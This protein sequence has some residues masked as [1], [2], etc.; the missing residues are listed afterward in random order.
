MAVGDARRAVGEAAHCKI[1]ILI[2]A[3]F[4]EAALGEFTGD[5]SVDTIADQVGL[6]WSITWCSTPPMYTNVWYFEKS[7]LGSKLMFILPR[8][9]GTRA[10]ATKER[11]APERAKKNE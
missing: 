7:S 1:G 5:G 11:P 10:A 4:L 9:S 3:D 8:A 2:A 6:N